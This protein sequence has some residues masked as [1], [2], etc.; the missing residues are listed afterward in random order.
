MSAQSLIGGGG[1]QTLSFMPS[2]SSLELSTQLGL[3]VASGGVPLQ[4][5]RDKLKKAFQLSDSET[6]H[7]VDIQ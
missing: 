2:D 5:V 4:N 7:L 6:E 3:G 1:S